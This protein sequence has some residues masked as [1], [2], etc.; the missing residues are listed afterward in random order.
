MKRI[1]FSEPRAAMNSLKGITKQAFFGFFASHIVFTLIIDGQA[2]FPKYFFPVILQDLLQFYISNFN[3]PLMKHVPLWFQSLIVL[4]FCIQ[5]PFFF[6]ACWYLSSKCSRYPS[7]FRMACIT[8]GAHVA[9]SMIPILSCLVTNTDA[10][11]S[12]RSRV[13]GAYLPYL[14]FPLW[15]WFIAINDD[16]KLKEI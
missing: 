10:T 5:L 2:I 3:D 1:G 6:V 16:E 13:V 7:W 15:I 9:T 14:I 11:F 4:E 8:Y 12:E